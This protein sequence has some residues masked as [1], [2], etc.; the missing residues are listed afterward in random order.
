M[1][2]ALQKK[3]WKLLVQIY[4]DSKHEYKQAIDM[5]RFKITN[6]RDKVDLL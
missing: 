1:K 3:R 2:L 4:I 5:I 6:L